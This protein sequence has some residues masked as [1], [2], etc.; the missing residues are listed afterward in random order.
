MRFAVN[1]K[2]KRL[3][4]VVKMKWVDLVLYVMHYESFN[5]I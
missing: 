2:D 3:F 4:A 1:E 5:S